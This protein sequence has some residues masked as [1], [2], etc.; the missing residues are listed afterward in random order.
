[1]THTLKREGEVV[2]VRAKLKLKITLMGPHHKQLHH[3]VHPQ[4]P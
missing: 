1:L 2:T 4:A 3:L